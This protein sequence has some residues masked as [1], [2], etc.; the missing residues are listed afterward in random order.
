[1]AVYRL[2]G[3][4]GLLNRRFF[5]PLPDIDKRRVGA[6]PQRLEPLTYPLLAPERIEVL[7]REAMLLYA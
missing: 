4:V 1:M 7:F 5:L 3:F 6:G 2:P